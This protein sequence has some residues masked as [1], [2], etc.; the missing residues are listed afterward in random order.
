M[1]E[2]ASANPA[3]PGSI[4]QELPQAFDHVIEKALAKDKTARYSSAAEMM[5]AL[6]AIQSSSAPVK[7]KRPVWIAAAAAAVLVLASVFFLMREWSTPKAHVPNPE[8][9]QLYLQ[10]RRDLQEFTEHGFKQSVVDFSNAIQRDPD[11]A[12]AYAGLADAYS[13]Q[14]LFE[15][16]RPKDVMPLAESNAAKAIEKDPALAEA[17]TSLAIVALGFY[18]DFPL[19]EQRFERSLKIDPRDAFTQHYLGH[20]YESV[21]RWQ[22]ALAQMQRALAAEKLSPM[23]GEDL[24]IDLFLNRR[25]DDAERQLRETVGLAPEDP[26]AHAVLALVLEAGGKPAEALEQAEKA[27]TLPGMFLAAGSLSGVFSRLHQTERARDIL[28]QLETAQKQGNYVSPVEIAMAQFAL[29]N[30][31]EGLKAVRDAIDDRSIN[32]VLNLFD[33]V[34]DLVREDPEFK[35]LMNQI[36]VPAAC[37]HDVPRYLKH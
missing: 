25:V 6:Q 18:R 17:Y 11:Y 31:A 29:G 7:P 2:I 34:F 24:G 35:A 28:N 5:Q 3:R 20:Y 16:V 27:A 19:A 1:H 22:D 9:Y 13:Y 37:W 33:P 32:L 8:A 21:G 12:A 14:G 10:G 26:F 36:N 4:R 23:Y 30:R 15:L